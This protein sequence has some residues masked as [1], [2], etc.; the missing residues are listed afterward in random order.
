MTGPALMVCGTGSDVGKSRLVT[1]LCRAFARRGLTV[2]PFKGQNM[3]LNSAV[4]PDGAEIGRAQA[5]QAQAAGAVP[6]ATMNP[7]LLKPTSSRRS[8]VVVM[9]RPWRELDAAE[10]QR[11]KPALRATVAGALADLR[12]RF[13]VVVCEGA[14]S[15]AEVNLLDHD[16]VNLG[17]AAD[18][19]IPAILVGDID[20]GGVFA[21]LYGTVALLP[22]DRRRLVHGFVVNKLRGDPAL[23]GDATEILRRRCGI[24]TLGVVPHIEGLWLD[25]EDSLGLGWPAPPLDGS[26]D[27]TVIDVA[28]VRL[29]RISNFTD[30]DPLAAEPGV[31]LRQVDHPGAIGDPD[32]LVLPGS[33]S[34]VADLEWLRSRGLDRAIE[35]L[36][37]A[38][39]TVLGVCGGY[40]MLGCRIEDP[41]GVE[42]PERRTPGLGLLP[43]VTRFHPEKL[44]VCRTGITAGAPA[45]AAAGYEIHHGRHEVDPGAAAWFLF[46]AHG[47]EPGGAPLPEGVADEPGGIYGSAL[48]GLF[49]LDAFRAAF[50]AGVAAR[51]GKRLSPSGVRFHA[52]REAQIDRLA[53]A[54]EEHLT[55]AALVKLAGEPQ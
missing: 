26:G 44:T 53:D 34:T 17:L 38:G 31:G 8:Q 29:P 46:G 36:R 40:Q 21:Q 25:A 1:G 13:D 19:G 32:L 30:F 6:E 14:G 23:L 55:V 16:L 20:R 12:A 28:V 4:T 42:S 9:G 49:E 37:A 52:V 24:P 45:L 54:C 39:T 27:G 11:T 3:A 15:P 5:A 2:A 51:R 41:D 43:L 33:K 48:H 47:Q 18:A 35:R 10:Y 7:V 22:A 50:L